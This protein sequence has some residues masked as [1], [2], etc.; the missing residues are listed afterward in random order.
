MKVGEIYEVNC[1]FWTS[2]REDKLIEMEGSVRK[3][4][5]LIKKGEFIELRFPF[6]WHFRT[7]D[8]IYFHAPGHILFE[9][10]RYFGL[11]DEKVRFENKQKLK[12]IL[13][14]RLFKGYWESEGECNGNKV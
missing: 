8:D 12:E 14:L 3:V 4:R 11:I 2:G 13:N 1:D 6:E 10:C 5:S 9:N 7:L